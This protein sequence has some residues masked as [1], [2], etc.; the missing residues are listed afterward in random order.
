MVLDGRIAD[1]T[2]DL[3]VRRPEDRPGCI[4]V[5]GWHEL[6]GGLRSFFI[7]VCQ[8][9]RD[10]RIVRV[11]GAF[12]T[13]TGVSE[14]EAIGT[15]V[16]G[17]AHEMNNP[18]T[19]VV[20]F[21]SLLAEDES[22]PPRG[23]EDA[24]KILRQAERCRTIV[25]G[26]LRFSRSGGE[27]LARRPLRLDQ[28]L[29]ECVD[30]QHGTFESARIRLERDLGTDALPIEGDECRLIQVFENLFVN[31]RQA[32]EGAG[33]TGTAVARARRDGGH[34]TVEVEDEGP[35]IAEMHRIFEPYYTTKEP[36]EGTGLGLSVSR[37]I[38]EEHGGTIEA[39]NTGGGAPLPRARGAS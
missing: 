18:L 27:P 24:K 15:K 12:E 5:R 37:T 1:W 30:L 35:G 28:V 8:Y 16:A 22:L 21:A 19:G 25:H 39:E 20:G 23:A 14:D 34:I 32:M 29:A 31:A 13:I 11:N 6:P 2:R 36:G 33:R 38:V 17:I 10:R 4:E 9:D 26:L 3:Y 7:G